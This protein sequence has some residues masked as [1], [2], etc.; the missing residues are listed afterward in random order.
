MIWYFYLLR[1]NNN[2]LYSGI[3]NDLKKRI[4]KHNKGKGAK[5][6]AYNKPVKLE[7]FEKFKN[8]SDVIKREIQVKSWNKAEKEQMIKGF[9][10]NSKY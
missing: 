10:K 9:P 4:E 8:K 2:A 6:T 7:Y 1:C 3:T 5:Y